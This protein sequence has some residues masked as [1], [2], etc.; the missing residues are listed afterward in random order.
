MEQVRAADGI[1]LIR[2]P[3]GEGQKI[4]RIA[5]AAP[6]VGEGDGPIGQG[7]EPHGGFAFKSVAGRKAQKGCRTIKPAPGAGGDRHGEPLGEGHG[8]CGGAGLR[9]E[10]AR[11]RFAPTK[12]VQQSGRNAPGF[13]CCRIATGFGQGRE[14]GEAR[15]VRAIDVQDLAA[16][17]LAPLAKAKAVQR[18]G[19]K[20]TAD[21]V[22][23]RDGQCMSVMMLHADRLNTET[24]G[25][26]G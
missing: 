9:R 12:L 10:A 8:E 24:I 18:H 25:K 3:G 5:F 6:A 19:K 22:F 15:E 16:P 13:A 14:M 17:G 23:R 2:Q 20:G 4:D 21:T 26:S 1:G 7:F 11:N